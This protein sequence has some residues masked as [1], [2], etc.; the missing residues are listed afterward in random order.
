MYQKLMAQTRPGT[1]K[2]VE[3]FIQRWMAYVQKLCQRQAEVLAEANQGITEMIAA[4]PLDQ[5]PITGA[6]SAVTA[7]FQNI[8]RKVDRAR[9]K[10]FDEM[11]PALDEIEIQEGQEELA[12]HQIK[13][14]ILRQASDLMQDIE[15]QWIMMQ[16]RKGAE[17]ARAMYPLAAREAEQPQPCPNCAAQIQM[18]V[19]YAS[20]NITCPYCKSVVT[21]Q[22]GLAASL[23]YQGLGVHS[24]A[25][26]Q[27]LDIWSGLNDLEYEYGKKRVPTDMDRQQYIEAT[28]RYWTEYYGAVRKLNPQYNRTVEEAV[29]AKLMHF[30]QGQTVDDKQN[31]H[32]YGKVHQAGKARDSNALLQLAS[33]SGFSWDDAVRVMLEHGDRDG[34]VFVLRHY[35]KAEQEDDPID[36]WI[37]YQIVHLQT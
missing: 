20:V 32:L 17:W 26:E 36:Q 12:V 35:H 24:L 8:R 7:R 16:T 21:M 18:G 2:V 37:A 4:N 6:F 23:Y 27:T 34:A 33:S 5:V 13:E 14:I 3:P 11:S 10:L 29:S 30:D 25:D 22:P 1:K 9:E 28:R 31:Q 19:M 15:K